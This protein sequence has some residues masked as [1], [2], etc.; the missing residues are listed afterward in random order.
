MTLDRSDGA[1]QRRR[2]E[3]TS[4]RQRPGPPPLFDAAA[5][6]RLAHLRPRDADYVRLEIRDPTVWRAAL[7]GRTPAA[8]LLAS[9]AAGPTLAAELARR[10]GDEP[11]AA[12]LCQLLGG[13]FPPDLPLKEV[14][15]PWLE[16][17]EPLALGRPGDPVDHGLF[18]S[19][20]TKL[21][22]LSLAA[23]GAY[24]TDA[25]LDAARL[26]Y[27]AA[28]PYHAHDAV[29]CAVVCAGAPAIDVLLQHLGDTRR[30][31]GWRSRR[32]TH[33]LHRWARRF[34]YLP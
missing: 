12:T 4:P 22:R 32:K 34:G 27:A 10:L 18:P 33:E 19:R 28:R 14:G 30:R 31:R 6:A 29:A 1:G 16:R 21:A 11:I 24:P 7:D 17:L 23:A 15:P 5:L 3:P 9:A 13:P 8:L 20:A 26:A 25:V 2:V